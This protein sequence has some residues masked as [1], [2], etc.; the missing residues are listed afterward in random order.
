[1]KTLLTLAILTTIATQAQVVNIHEPGKVYAEIP[2]TYTPITGY[3]WPRYHTRTHAHYAEGWRD[4]TEMPVCDEGYTVANVAWTLVDDVAV[5][6]WDCDPI[7]PPPA[8]DAR[9]LAIAEAYRTTLR[10]MYGD[11][12]ETD[13]DVTRQ[14]VEDDLLAMAMHDQGV[15]AIRAAMILERGFEVITQWT[16]S[17][18][19]WS[20]FDQHN[21]L[22]DGA[23]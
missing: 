16:G 6:T 15:D 23:E 3:R 9:L 12:A 22:L 11:T 10:G 17:A 5:V 21:E 14:R 7:P 19:T 2:H 13:R 8:P 4:A 20:F 18:E 1:M